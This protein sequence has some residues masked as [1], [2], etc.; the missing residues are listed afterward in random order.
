MSHGDGGYSVF[1]LHIAPLRT[2]VSQLK[3]CEFSGQTF[4]G[5]EGIQHAMRMR[6][7]HLWPAQLY[8][9]FLHYLINRMNVQIKNLWNTK[10]V[11]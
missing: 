8:H 4:K 1:R 10:C 7:G 9:I 6:K 5:F 2:T 3:M 11:F